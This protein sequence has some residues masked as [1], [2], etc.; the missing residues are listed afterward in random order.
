MLRREQHAGVQAHQLP[1]AGERRAVDVD[2]APFLAGQA[3]A[4]V[5]RRFGAHALQANA[6]KGLVVGDQVLFPAGPV[7]A[8]ETAEEDGLQ[9]VGLS[10]RVFPHDQ[11]D[12][13]LRRKF[14]VR[15]VPEI[16]QRQ[17]CDAHV[18][19]PPCEKRGKADSTFPPRICGFFIPPCA[20]AAPGRGSPRPRWGPRRRGRCWN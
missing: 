16:R 17:L 18:V 19:P 20:P 13:A 1:D 4:Q 7:R 3:H 12:A 10:L 6:R 8:P 11:V 5:V 2:L 9:Q 15:V 14:A